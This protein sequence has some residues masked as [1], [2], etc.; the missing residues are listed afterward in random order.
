[1]AGSACIQCVESK[2]RA[3]LYSEDRDVRKM[4]ILVMGTWFVN[5]EKQGEFNR[6]WKKLLG[7]MKKKPKMFKEVKSIKLL[8]QTFGGTAGSHVEL[9]EY[10]S[11]ADYEALHARLMKKKEF[12]KLYQELMLV[13]EPATMTESVLTALE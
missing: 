7:L 10:E 6:L 8:T 9:V 11:L 4:T 5:P 3:K 1:M 12:M 13:I 2:A